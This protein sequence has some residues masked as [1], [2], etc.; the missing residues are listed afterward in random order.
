MSEK[1]CKRIPPGI[2]V[3]AQ[4]QECGNGFLGVFVSGLRV[5]LENLLSL[6][7]YVVSER[8]DKLFKLR[9]HIP[10]LMR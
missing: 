9:Y 7:L 5:S 6:G 8:L 1:H 4:F 3:S 2:S 10:F